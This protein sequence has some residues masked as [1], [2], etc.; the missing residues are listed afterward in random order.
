MPWLATVSSRLPTSSINPQW[1]IAVVVICWCTTRMPLDNVKILQSLIIA[2]K[3][4][5]LEV[6]G[7][8][9]LKQAYL[10]RFKRCRIVLCHGRTLLPGGGQWFY[11]NP[12]NQ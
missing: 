11:P 7:T 9:A 10:G 12:P 4:I 2:A 6:W 8:E 5:L 1:T 3:L